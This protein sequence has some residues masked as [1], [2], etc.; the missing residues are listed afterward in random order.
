MKKFNRYQFDILL[1]LVLIFLQVIFNRFYFDRLAPHSGQVTLSDP[2]ILPLLEYP[3]GSILY[4]PLMVILYVT[5]ITVFTLRKPRRPSLYYGLGLV[6]VAQANFWW[7]LTM[8]EG[9]GVE[10]E[11]VFLPQLTNMNGVMLAQDATMVV[12]IVMLLIKLGVYIIE[13]FHDIR[14]THQQQNPQSKP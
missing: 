14:L 10:I 13:I 11:N 5:L 1:F 7:G 6:L 3:G 2:G 12:L 9:T 4:I 8:N